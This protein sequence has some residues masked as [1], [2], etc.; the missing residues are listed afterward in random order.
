M[1][2]VKV[3]RTRKVGG[4]KRIVGLCGPSI[5]YQTAEEVLSQMRAGSVRYYVRAESW[6]A[7]VRVV[8]EDGELTLVTTRDV[9]SRNN[10]ANLSDC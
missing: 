1:P 5:G 3:T 4:G 10:L 2:R 7:D 8:E 9:L 6:E